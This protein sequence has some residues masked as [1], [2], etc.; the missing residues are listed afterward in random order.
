MANVECALGAH[1]WVYLE[2]VAATYIKKINE[3]YKGGVNFWSLRDDF[4]YWKRHHHRDKHPVRGEVDWSEYYSCKGEETL[5]EN[6]TDCVG[7][8]SWTIHEGINSPFSLSTYAILPEVFKGLNLKVF[9]FNVNGLRKT[10]DEEKWGKLSHKVHRSLYEA[11]LQVQ[12]E[13]TIFWLLCVLPFTSYKREFP[14]GSRPH[15]RTGW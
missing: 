13:D 1:Q 10:S 8:F 3:T 7:L 11:S 4:S 2:T 15:H 5:R 12:C 14:M 6:E 9:S